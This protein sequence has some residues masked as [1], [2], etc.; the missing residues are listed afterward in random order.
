NLGVL[1]VYEVWFQNRRA[2]WRKA[3]RLKEEQRKREDPERKRDPDTKDAPSAAAAN[4]PDAAKG[5]GARAG[6]PEGAESLAGVGLMCGCELGLAPAAAARPAGLPASASAALR[7]REG[8]VWATWTR[9]YR[10]APTPSP[11][12]S[13]RRASSPSRPSRPAPTTPSPLPRPPVTSSAPST[14]SSTGTEPAPPPPPA[15]PPSHP[16]PRAPA[17]VPGPFGHGL[18]P[19]FG[20]GVTD[21]LLGLTLK[22]SPLQ[23]FL[24]S[25]LLHSDTLLKADLERAV[26]TGTMGLLDMWQGTV[27][28]IQRA[29]CSE[30]HSRRHSVLSTHY[31]ALFK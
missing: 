22:Q 12:A 8:C 29:L 21:F 19:T 14:P 13:R 16:L 25:V 10:P 24:S 5:D 27:N 3:E 4:D 26:V 17:A 6:S 20:D 9:P 7:R 23:V 30:I 2:K 18:F 1:V 15:L 28:L 11:R 31:S